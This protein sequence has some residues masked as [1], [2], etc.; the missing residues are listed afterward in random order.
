[1]NKNNIILW[2]AFISSW[3]FG[4][5][6]YA[7]TN[8]TCATAAPF[9]DNSLAPYPATTGV[10]NAD[11]GNNYDCLG[12]QPN[13]AWLTMTVGISGNLDFTLMNTNNE[14]I[15]FIVWGPFADINA[16]FAACGNLGNGGAGGNS[17]S[18]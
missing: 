18:L 2:I 5:N 6:S 1:M 4:I 15:D 17:V 12:L 10:P 7:Q 16:A 9:C 3:L 8:A 11:P 14:D 13:P